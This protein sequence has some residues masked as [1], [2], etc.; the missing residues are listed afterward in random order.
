[1]PFSI[2]IFL[3]IVAYCLTEGMIFAAAGKAGKKTSRVLFVRSIIFVALAGLIYFHTECTRYVDYDR[4]STE[5][6]LSLSKGASYLFDLYSLNP[7]SAV[8]LALIAKTGVF[9]LLKSLSA[10][11]YYGV[12]LYIAGKLRQ[13]YGAFSATITTVFFLC[14]VDLSYPA[15]NIRFPI[16]SAIF[17][18]G[19]VGYSYFSFSPIKA[20]SLMLFGCFFHASMWPFLI[21]FLSTRI[22]KKNIF[23]IILT[24]FLI[25]YFQIVNLVSSLISSISPALGWKIQLYF[26]TDGQYYESLISNE[27][28]IYL[29]FIY[30]FICTLF[31]LK[32]TFSKQ[33][34]SQ[35]DRVFI[36]YSCFLLGSIHS[37]VIF[38]RYIPFLILISLPFIADIFSRYTNSGY[39]G[40]NS[41][42]MH[43]IFVSFILVSTF[44]LILRFAFSYTPFYLT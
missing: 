22:F 18:L 41:W 31:L 17:A 27:Q 20:L 42:A 16:A 24:F 44:G 28:F 11:V 8:P 5:M 32:R 13:T 10:C 37:N 12:L 9:P 35:S 26:E 25:F 39:T 38:P 36:M 29:L 40:K 6:S 2:G 34:N 4:M 43:F 14:T 19:Y 30:I 3:Y 15:D 7:L 1:M 21:I 23:I 33:E